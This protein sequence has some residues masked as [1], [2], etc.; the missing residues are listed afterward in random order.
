MESAML[1]LDAEKEVFAAKCPK[2]QGGPLDLT[3]D[4]QPH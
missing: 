3:S 2:F 4:P 1:I